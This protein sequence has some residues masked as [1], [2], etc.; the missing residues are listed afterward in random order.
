MDNPLFGNA[1]RQGAQAEINKRW[2]QEN[3]LS[4]ANQKGGGGVSFSNE[5]S[6]GNP[7]LTHDPRVLDYYKN[8]NQEIVDRDPIKKG[9]RRRN[10]GNPMGQG[11]GGG[12]GARGGGNDGGMTKGRGGVAFN[13]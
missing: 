8:V 5:T 6:F 2:A 3:K 4:A 7:L 13:L 9:G 1:Y 11:R 10:R 12:G